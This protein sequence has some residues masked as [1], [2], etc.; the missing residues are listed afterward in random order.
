MEM[1]LLQKAVMLKQQSEE[2]EKQL[3]FVSEQID[4]LER[5]SRSL[6]ELSEDKEKEILAPLGRGVYMKADKKSEKLFVEVGAGVLV[7]KT[8]QEA[9]DI[10]AGQLESFNAAKTQ[11]AAQLQEFVQEFGRMLGEVERLKK[12]NEL[13]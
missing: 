4:D 6:K 3:N 13:D 7:R 9:I 11:L 8:P 1:E 5:F 10:I 2:V 12:G